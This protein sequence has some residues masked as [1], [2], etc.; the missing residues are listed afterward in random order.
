VKLFVAGATGVL[1]S[2]VVPLLVAAGHDVTGVARSD[3]K[4]ASLRGAGANPV[5]VD[6]FDPGAV[7]KA[8]RGA[9]VVCNLAT[10][11]PSLVQAALPGAWAENDRIRN[12][13]SRNLVDA[14]LDAGATRFVQESV[15][16]L[17]ADGGD[18]WIDEQFPLDVPAYMRS[19]VAAES[20]ASRFTEAGGTGVVLRFGMFYGPGSSHTES[21]LAMARRRIGSAI[22]P[23]ERYWTMVHLDD[24]APAVVAALKVPAGVYNVVEDEPSTRAGQLDAVASALG[25]QKLRSP[26]RVMA[27]AGGRKTRALARSQRVT[28]RRFK[29]LSGW[30]PRYPDARGGWRATVAAMGSGP[31]GSG[32]QGAVS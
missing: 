6:L 23:K 11:I 8:V 9:E 24:A 7:Q 15:V 22:G 28:N 25:V 27:V 2:R 31:E 32:V 16:F 19:V 3:E 20:Q 14:A 5:G 17:Y 26:S 13:V 29:E 10:H 1:G 12:D 18:R 30:A 4:A 21:T